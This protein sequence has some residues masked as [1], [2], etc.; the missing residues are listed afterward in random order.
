MKL[1]KL[2]KIKRLNG[3]IKVKYKEIHVEFKCYSE[4]KCLLR[5]TTTHNN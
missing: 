2:A 1:I 3:L 4:N 5:T